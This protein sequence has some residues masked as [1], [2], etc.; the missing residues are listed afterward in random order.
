MNLLSSAYTLVAA[1]ATATTTSKTSTSSS[2]PTFLIVLVVVF[3]ALYFFLIRPSQRKR[4]QAVRQTRAY[5]VG[6]EVIAGG[7]VGHV[8]RIGDGEVDVD[9]GDGV[10]TFVPQAV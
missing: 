7:M 6:D 1:T 4:M 3:G 8:V 5:D 9:A 2:S 10:F